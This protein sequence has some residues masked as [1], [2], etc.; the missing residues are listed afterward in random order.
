LEEVDSFIGAVEVMKECKQPQFKPDLKEVI[1]K[2]HEI[3]EGRTT[4]PIPENS[5]YN[6]FLSFTTKEDSPPQIEFHF[7]FEVYLRS[8]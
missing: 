6:K 2:L 3:R 7:L 8:I 4:Y 5:L 1:D